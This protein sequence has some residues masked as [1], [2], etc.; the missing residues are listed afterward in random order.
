MRIKIKPSLQL[1]ALHLKV[2][3]SI[4]AYAEKHL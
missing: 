2:V 4:E 3:P 1:Q